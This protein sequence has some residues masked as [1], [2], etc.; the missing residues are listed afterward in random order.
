MK[1]SCC[2]KG[3]FLTGNVSVGLRELNQ[4][5]QR[6]SQDRC[7]VGLPGWAKK[8]DV[9]CLWQVDH[10]SFQSEA[11]DLHPRQLVLVLRRLHIQQALLSGLQDHINE[12]FIMF[13]SK[14]ISKFGHRFRQFFTLYI[15]TRLAFAPVLSSSFLKCYKPH[16]PSQIWLLREIVTILG[17]RR[18]LKHSFSEA[19]ALMSKYTTMQPKLRPTLRLF[20]P[21]LHVSLCSVQKA[22]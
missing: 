20:H 18:L 5:F 1:S 11:A 13:S 15:W 10:L 17:L 14:S 4:E 21:N 8:K 2:F 6:A 22:A 16:S 7:T 19:Q 9:L 3:L 12:Y